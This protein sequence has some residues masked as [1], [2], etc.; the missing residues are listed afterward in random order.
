MVRPE[1]IDTLVRK[2]GG[3]PGVPLFGADDRRE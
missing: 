1:Q 3:E 2:L